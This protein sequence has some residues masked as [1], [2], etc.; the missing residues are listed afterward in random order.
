[1]WHPYFQFTD[2][3]VV[4]PTPPTIS[5]GGH[6]GLVGRP[7]GWKKLKKLEE[8]LVATVEKIKEIPEKQYQFKI[9]PAVNELDKLQAKIDVFLSRMDAIS[10]ARVEKLQ[11]EANL[12]REAEIQRV[13]AENKRR[14]RKRALAIFLI[15]E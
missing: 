7:S 6:F 11:M 12:A 2:S 1:M 8:Q 3:G 4:P 10:A 13:I 15:E 9:S 14:K 5:I